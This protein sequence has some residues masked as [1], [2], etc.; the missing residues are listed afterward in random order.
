MRGCSWGGPAWLLPGGGHACLG[1]M[2]GEGGVC[3]EVGA[4]MAKGGVC[5]EGEHAW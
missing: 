3:G 4:C 1:G 2:R 5:G